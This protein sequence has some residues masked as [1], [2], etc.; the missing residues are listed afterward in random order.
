MSK[1]QAFAGNQLCGAV[2]TNCFEKCT[3][4]F[5]DVKDDLRN[6]PKRLIKTVN[7]ASKHVSSLGQ[8]GLY[9]FLLKG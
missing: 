7:G 1:L 5:A 2:C 6:V 3:Y 9:S 4:W 8:L